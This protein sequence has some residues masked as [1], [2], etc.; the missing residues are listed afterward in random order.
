VREM[1]RLL[2]AVVSKKA[3][4]QL[5]LRDDLPCVRADA[6]Q[7]RQVVM[8]L[9]TNASDALGEAPG[10]I[11]MRTRRMHAT[12]A[13]LRGAQAGT[14]I[15]E[16]DYLVLELSDTGVGMDGE[17]MARLFDPFYTTK[18]PGRGLGLAAVLGIVRGHLGA[19]R[20]TSSTEQ[21]TTVAV[22]LPVAG[23]PEV[24]AAVVP[25]SP[26]D[27]GTILL[28][29]DDSAALRVAERVLLREGYRVLRA[30]NGRA[31]LE[32]YA[33]RGPTIDLV[34]LDLTMPVLSDWETLRELRILDPTVRV[35]LMSGYAH[36]PDDSLESANGFL[37]KPYSAPELREAVSAVLTRSETSA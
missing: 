14:D 23:A 20:I 29:D 2:G 10:T 22:L 34:M 13:W 9:L 27:R 18:G 12:R 4:M 3:N 37:A 21:G 11:T 19:V 8:N 32:I 16:G 30:D 1:G 33:E 36:T 31:A 15:P 7:M 6:T 25:P 24:D 35:L 26:S 17:A 5:E 28:V